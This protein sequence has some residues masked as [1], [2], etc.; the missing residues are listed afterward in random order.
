MKKQIQKR[1][2]RNN[3]LRLILITTFIATPVLAQTAVEKGLEIAQKIESR[4]DGFID[5]RVTLKM[6]LTNRNGETS[7]RELRLASL[8][9]SDTSLGD[10][11]LTV[12]DRPRDIRGTAFLS[13][14]KILDPDDQWL[15]LPALKR[16]KRISSANK[17]GPFVGSEFAYEDLV[18][19]EVEKYDFK[20]LRDEPCGELQCFVLERTP[21]Y[22]KS[23]Y[24]RQV[25]WVDNQ[26]YRIMR[27][28]YYDRKASLLKTLQQSGFKQYVGQYWRP[29]TMIMIN[30]QTGKQ[31][32]LIFEDYKFRTGV[33]ENDFTPGR[34]KRIR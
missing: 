12:F 7:T 29:S 4:D 6:T 5:S 14:T 13:F 24:S 3:A 10:K 34:L 15:F 33:R 27:V 23:G 1:F 18:S 31:T 21:R 9:T 22:A 32:Q 26:E 17:S 8:E 16:V 30:Q 25:T 11:S 2:L 19:F 28:D 20:W